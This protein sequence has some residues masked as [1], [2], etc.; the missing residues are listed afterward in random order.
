MRGRNRI[1]RNQDELPWRERAIVA[2]SRSIPKL[3]LDTTRHKVLR[4]YRLS[5]GRTCHHYV[6]R[7]RLQRGR[8]KKLPLAPFKA[9]TT[10]IYLNNNSC[11]NRR[12]TYVNFTQECTMGQ[13]VYV[14][15]SQGVLGRLASRFAAPSLSSISIAALIC[16]TRQ[17]SGRLPIHSQRPMVGCS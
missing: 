5:T 7:Q 1:R 12:L 6:W 13:A 4:D 9:P 16:R 3:G 8:L 14:I 11:A 15:H 10:H 17:P 2:A